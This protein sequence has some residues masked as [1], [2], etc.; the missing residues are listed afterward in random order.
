MPS[1]LFFSKS[2]IHCGFG[3]A[4]EIPEVK[5]RRSSKALNI[6]NIKNDEEYISGGKYLPDDTRLR[7]IFCIG[8]KVTRFKGDQRDFPESAP[9]IVLNDFP[10]KGNFIIISDNADGTKIGIIADRYDVMDKKEVF[11]IVRTAICLR[12]ATWLAQLVVRPASQNDSLKEHYVWR[13]RGYYPG[14]EVITKE[15]LRMLIRPKIIEFLGSRENEGQYVSFLR[16]DESIGY[17]MS[18]FGRLLI[19]M[20]KEGELLVRDV[21]EPEEHVRIDRLWRLNLPVV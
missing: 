20:E 2:A 9:T 1:H 21:Y 11:Q 19:N 12:G 18:E 16:F 10:I 14:N 6:Q 8:P 13:A 7:P 5:P 17:C 3:K 4:F 15:Y